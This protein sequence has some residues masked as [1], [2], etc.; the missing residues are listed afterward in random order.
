[1]NMRERDADINKILSKSEHIFE[2]IFEG[3]IAL[4]YLD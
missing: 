4:L 2:V 3:S 1:M